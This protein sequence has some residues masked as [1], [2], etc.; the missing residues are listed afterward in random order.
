MVTPLEG[1]ITNETTQ[2]NPT[3]AVYMGAVEEANTLPAGA[4]V[5]GSEHG[6]AK[7]ARQADAIES[8]AGQGAILSDLRRA[9]NARSTG[10]AGRL[11][12]TYAGDARLARGESGAQ[13]AKRSGQSNR[14]EGVARFTKTRVLPL[15]GNASSVLGI[16]SSGSR[17]EVDAVVGRGCALLTGEA[18]GRSQEVRHH[19]FE[20][21][22]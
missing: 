14:E 12:K 1:V 22:S 13:Q 11:G 20:L 16:P 19:L 15:P 5:H 18:Q 10:A 2:W 3:A 17:D 21:S 4:R 8:L 6:M 9:E 7:D